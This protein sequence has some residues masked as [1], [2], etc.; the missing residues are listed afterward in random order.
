MANRSP[1]ARSEQDAIRQIAERLA[2]QF[3]EISASEV[4]Q[5]VH[6]KHGS[7]ASSSVRDFIPVLVERASRKALA[8]MRA[9][10]P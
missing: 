2:S 5:T 9:A 4:E 8:E 1:H 3:P 10:G 7:F 6:G